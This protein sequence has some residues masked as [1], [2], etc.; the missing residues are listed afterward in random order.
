MVNREAFFFLN[1]RL[2]IIHT[3]NE[4]SPQRHRVHRERTET[5]TKKIETWNIP[6]IIFVRVCTMVA[7]R[8]PGL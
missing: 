8:I 6:W 7:I 2:F 3:T 4:L 1:H 5:N